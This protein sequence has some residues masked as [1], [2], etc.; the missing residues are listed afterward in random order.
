MHQNVYT[1]DVS[2]STTCFGTSQV[3]SSGSPL[4]TIASSSSSSLSDDRFETSSKTIPPHI[5]IQSF[6]L[7]M[8]ISSSVLKLIQQLLTS[9]SFSSCHF[10]LPFY[11]PSI[12][13]F[14]RQFLRKMWPIQLTFRFLIACRIFL[15]SL[16]WSN[17]SS[18]LTWSVQLIF[19]I[20]LLLILTLK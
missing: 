10:Y 8:R 5:A 6:L 1:S 16:T 15:C 17:T 18:F 2:K 4:S 11:L 3:P 12:T 9:S 19:S 20:L 7:Q 13:Y 14:K